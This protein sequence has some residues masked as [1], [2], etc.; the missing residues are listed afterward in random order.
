MLVLHKRKVSPPQTK[1]KMKK[2]LVCCWRQSVSRE[3]GIL[4]RGSVSCCTMVPALAKQS[5]SVSAVAAG[6]FRTWPWGCWRCLLPS[7]F[8]ALSFSPT[9]PFYFPSLLRTPTFTVI[10]QL[11]RVSSFS[12]PVCFVDVTCLNV[13]L[14]H[15]RCSVGQVFQQ[16]WS[17]WLPRRTAYP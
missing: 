5:D 8:S 9:V 15:V 11:L 1:T 13:S 16:D 4:S 14:A 12:L 7:A 6:E 10:L 3:N 2:N 17:R